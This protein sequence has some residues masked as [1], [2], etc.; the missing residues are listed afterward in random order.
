VPDAGKQITDAYLEVW[1]GVCN[2]E[3]LDAL[4]PHIALLSPLYSALRYHYDI[5]PQMEIQWEMEN[6]V[7][8]NLTLLLKA[9]AR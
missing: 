3:T 5:L 1:Q 8:Y 9:L 6:M 4:M 2:R 7:N